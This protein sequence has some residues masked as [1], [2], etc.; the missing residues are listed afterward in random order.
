MDDVMKP[1]SVRVERASISFHDLRVLVSVALVVVLWI[2][3]IYALSVG[4]WPSPSDFTSAVIH[5]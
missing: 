1:A 5:P 2:V 4:P 3:A